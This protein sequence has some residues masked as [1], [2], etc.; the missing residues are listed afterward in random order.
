VSGKERPSFAVQARVSDA[1]T[2]TRPSWISRRT[3]SSRPPTPSPSPAV[4]EPSIASPPEPAAGQAAPPPP[5]VDLGMS[6]ELARLTEE[7]ASLNA[8]VA[9]MAATMARLRRDVLQSSEPELVQLAVTIA[10][11]VVGRELALEPA[12]VV[13]WT[14]DA[15]EALAA[16]GE[17]IIAL[18]RDV[19]QQVPHE[20][21]NAIEVDHRVQADASL[22]PSTIEVRTSDGV[23]AAGFEARL[24]AVA[25][26]LGVTES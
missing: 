2:A 13:A 5:A 6:A 15:I 10:E 18:A 26:A 25:Q 20:A 8:K 9:E 17:V 14:R 7:N 22:A 23:V 16:K 11:R 19:A 12:L 1:A 4:T 3:A 24:A 21:W